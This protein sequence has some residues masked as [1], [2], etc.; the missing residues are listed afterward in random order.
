MKKQKISA[1]NQQ[2]SQRKKIRLRSAQDE[3]INGN[4]GEVYHK[5]KEIEQRLMHHS[6]EHFSKGKE[7]KVCKDKRVQA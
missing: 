4:T 7:E 6:I 5:K 1:C 2:R 3:D